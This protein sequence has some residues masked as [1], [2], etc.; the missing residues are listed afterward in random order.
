[1]PRRIARACAALAYG[2]AVALTIYPT[3]ILVTRAET[4]EG[5]ACG[6]V[7]LTVLALLGALVLGASRRVTTALALTAAL[8]LAFVVARAPDGVPLPDARATS[9]FHP[10]ARYPRLSPFNLVPEIDQ[11]KLGAI[12]APDIAARI[13]PG[14]TD[15]VL[16]V[17]M[18]IYRALR[19]DPELAALGSV[20]HHTFTDTRLAHEWR[21]T[22]PHRPG[23]RLPLLVFFHGSGGNFASYLW[24]WRQ[25]A[26]RLHAAVVL[27]TMG[28]GRRSCDDV[29]L[30]GDPAIDAS[31][32]WVAGLSS[33][34]VQAMCTARKLGAACKAAVLVSPVDVPAAP[35][36]VPLLIVYGDRDDVLDRPH[37]AQASTAAR[38]TRLVY[39]G[40]DHFLMFS[41]RERFLADL[42]RWL[43]SCGSPSKAPAGGP[44]TAP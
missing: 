27:P 11:V 2:L 42:E 32:V 1:M 14:A 23:E 37:L 19:A 13:G 38:V 26:D 34:A 5:R 36:G 16:A 20:L 21:Y 9:V 22:P 17:T 31:R 18:P 29:A 6:A 15:R 35:P 40:E 25:A 4:L 28:W 12:L 44:A 30:P 43:R 10:P 41:A 8:L 24:F 3:A 39:A 33:G 7:A